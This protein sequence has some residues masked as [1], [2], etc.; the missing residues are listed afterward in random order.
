MSSVCLVTFCAVDA[1]DVKDTHTSCGLPR[2]IDRGTE[3]GKE[4]G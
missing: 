2:F 3:A 4:E 1:S